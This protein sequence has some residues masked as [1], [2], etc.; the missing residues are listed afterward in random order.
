MAKKEVTY[1]TPEQAGTRD[2][3]VGV[4]D[5]WYRHREGK[6][7]E[8]YERGWLAHKREDVDYKIIEAC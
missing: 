1:I 5:K 8:E 4:Y 2:A 6:T 3:L 7:A